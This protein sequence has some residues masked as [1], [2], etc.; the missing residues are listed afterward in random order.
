MTRK[1]STRPGFTLVEVLAA[2]LLIGIVL[3]AVMTGVSIAARAATEA[4]HRTEAANLAQSKLAELLATDAWQGGVMQGDFS[5]DSP[6]YKWQ[7]TVQP[8][9]NDT[10]TASIQQIDLRVSWVSRN[11][12]GSVTVSTLA[13]ASQ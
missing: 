3:P 11:V 5:P 7:A 8:W 10:T 6:G 1:R 12:E 9:G 2:M 4:R 13:Y